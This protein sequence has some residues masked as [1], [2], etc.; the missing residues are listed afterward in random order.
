MRPK[1][2]LCGASWSS[3]GG[4]FRFFGDLDQ[5][6][7]KGIQR[8]LVLGLGR[9]DHQRLV[10]DEREVVGRRMEIVI[11]QPLGDIQGAD[12][13]SVRPLAFGHELVHADAVVWDGIDT[14]QARLEVVGIQHG[15]LG[16]LA[17]AVRAVHGNVGVGTHEHAEVTVE[18]LDAPDGFLRRD[19][20]EQR[21]LSSSA[22]FDDPDDGAGQEVRQFFG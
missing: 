15:I 14:L 6:I 5:G 20:A 21:R 8:V 17:Q 1:G 19:E 12:A 9:L 7:R 16:D 11:H 3:S 2:V 4:R 18:G 22:F 10:D 13:G